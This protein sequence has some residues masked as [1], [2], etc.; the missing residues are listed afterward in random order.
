[1]TKAPLP[2]AMRLY[3]TRSERLYI[4]QSERERL[5]ALAE[6]KEPSLKAFVLT[7]IYTGCRIS[8]ALELTES[9]L[10]KDGGILSI[11]T[12]KRRTFHMREIPVPP[13]LVS[14][15]EEHL[16]HKGG[17]LALSKTENYEKANPEPEKQSF[18]KN[19]NNIP[20]W[21]NEA[22]EPINRITA[23]RWIKEIMREANIHGACASP[24][25]LRHGFGIHAVSSGVPLTLV[26]KWMGHSSI[27]TTA[28]YTNA[29]GE[30]ER[31]LAGRMWG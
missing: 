2:S 6:D 13:Q 4:N 29:V 1:M 12:L 11:R 15:L 10:Q 23:Y 9:S 31:R 19:Q 16:R 8:E 5:I 22:G 21:Q 28:I 20:L 26:A 24:K 25:G 30:E 14:A 17:H 18:P 7:L 27:K 3:G